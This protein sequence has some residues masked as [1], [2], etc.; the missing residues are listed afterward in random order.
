MVVMYVGKYCPAG[1]ETVAQSPACRMDTRETTVANAKEISAP[2]GVPRDIFG[3]AIL[4]TFLSKEEI[5][6]VHSGMC[7]LLLQ[8]TRTPEIHMTYSYMAQYAL[9]K[10][11]KTKGK[12][13][14]C[15]EIQ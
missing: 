12:D 10:P 6:F 13:K 15:K 9:N 14:H 1:V 11:P 4:K 5:L 7:C 2:S 8:E 3:L